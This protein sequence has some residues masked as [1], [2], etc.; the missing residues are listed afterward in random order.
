MIRDFLKQRMQQ[1]GYHA[2]IVRL[3]HIDELQAEIETLHSRGNVDESLYQWLNGFYRFAPPET[4]Y[5]IASIIIIASSSPQVR[6][7]FTW[8]GNR[9]PITM[10]PTYLD[11]IS[12]PRVIEKHLYESFCTTNPH[13]LMADNLPNKILAARSGLG[14]YGRNNL[15]YVPG[16]GSF[17]LLSAFYSDLPV[18]EDDWGEIKLMEPCERCSACMRNCP[19]GAITNK[20]YTIEAEKCIT[21]HNEFWGKA[22]FPDWIDPSAHNCIVGCM[23]CQ[24]ACPRNSEYIHQFIDIECFSEEETNFILEK[25]EVEALPEP[26]IQKLEKT[27]L[28]THY[29]YL[30]RNL[31][32]LLL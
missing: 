14:A 16:L 30:S 31:K 6:V 2:N 28:K 13:F 18:D 22:E 15:V 29:N 5:D 10:P 9:I 23:R 7:F 4:D 27:N 17:I 32:A 3:K 21:Y 8:K 19:T 11:F 26:F 25:K 20:R 12:K 24:N 1:Y